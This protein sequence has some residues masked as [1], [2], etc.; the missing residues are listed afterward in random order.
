MEVKETSGGKGLNNLLDNKLVN[1]D[2][3]GGG[4]NNKNKKF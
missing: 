3:L 4:K 2:N 1:L